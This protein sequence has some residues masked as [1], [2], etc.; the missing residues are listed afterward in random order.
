MNND[1]YSRIPHQYARVRPRYPAALF[2]WLTQQAPS[3]DLVWD[4]GTGSGQAAV[5][6]A[7]R[8][9]TVYA[10]D[11][12]AGP[13]V[14]APPVDNITWAVEPGEQ[15]SLRT[16]SADMITV[17]AALHWLNIE[18]FLPEVR[19]VLKPGGLLAAWTYSVAPRRGPVGD[20][21]VHYAQ[22]VLAQ[23]WN[24]AIDNVLNGYQDIPLPGTPLSPP[25]FHATSMLSFADTLDLMRTWSAAVAYTRR[26]G[27]DPVERIHD[28]LCTI[29]KEHVGALDA[30]HTL[31][32]PMTVRAH[33]LPSTTG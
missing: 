19:R 16:N 1:W 5:P 11:G 9:S 30:P 20:V 24:K 26:T 4:V 25:T 6:L 23:D 18:A 21:F 29:W 3:T 27:R 33:R 8:F 7:D 32:W 13:L 15:C 2:D 12:F 28:D 17:A 31:H 14:A 22:T 10:T